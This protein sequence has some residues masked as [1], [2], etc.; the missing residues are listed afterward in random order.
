MTAAGTEFKQHWLRDNLSYHYATTPAPQ[1]ENVRVRE[2]VN[3]RERARLTGRA[4]LSWLA[5]CGAALLIC[6]VGWP[7][8]NGPLFFIRRRVVVV[9]PWALGWAEGRLVEPGLL[10][11]KLQL[12]TWEK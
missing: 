5:G 1:N 12:A 3:E 4:V 9:L 7:A 8:Q 2:Y 6:Q 11:L 10:A